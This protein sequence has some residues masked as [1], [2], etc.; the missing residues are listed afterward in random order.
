MFPLTKSSRVY[1]ISS[2]YSNIPPCTFCEN[3]GYE[4]I[5]LCTLFTLPQIVEVCEDTDPN[6]FKAAQVSIGMLGVLTEVTVKVD[7]AFNLEEFRY[8]TTIDNCLKNLEEL[9]E[10]SHFQYVKFWMEFYNNF[11]VVYQ[12]RRTTMDVTNPPSD[13]VAFL[14]VSS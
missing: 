11:C 2:A 4:A 1:S 10:N 14:T 7:N 3:P 9:V 8:H 6:V 5:C 13:L 12:T